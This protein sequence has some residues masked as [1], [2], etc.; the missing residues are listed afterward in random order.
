MS[1]KRDNGYL[2]YKKELYEE[3]NEDVLTADVN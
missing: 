3:M 1:Y 2:K